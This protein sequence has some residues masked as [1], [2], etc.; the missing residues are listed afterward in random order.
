MDPASDSHRSSGLAI[1]SRSFDCDDLDPRKF[2]GMAPAVVPRIILYIPANDL[3][4]FDHHDSTGTIF[5]SGI[6]G[7]VR[8]PGFA[9]QGIYR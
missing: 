1:F 8:P 2:V 6:E 3:A 5:L 7:G 4:A 9:P